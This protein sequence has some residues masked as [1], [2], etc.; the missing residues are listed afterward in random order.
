MLR[1]VK[2]FI[3]YQ[4]T[5][6]WV[7]SSGKKARRMS[8]NLPTLEHAREWIIDYHYGQ[9][10]GIERRV[11]KQDRRQNSNI[12]LNPILCK[13]NTTSPG[14]RVTDKPIHIDIDLS[15]KKIKALQDSACEQ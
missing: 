5:Y 1:L 3:D 6:F 13:R 11:A 12:K 10:S 14:R 9:Y 15:K 4:F 7:E 2:D 8:K